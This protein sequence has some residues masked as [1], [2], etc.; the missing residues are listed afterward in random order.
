MVLPTDIFKQSITALLSWFYVIVYSL[1]L[2][3]NLLFSYN[4]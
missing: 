1:L 4:L 2:L 3:S